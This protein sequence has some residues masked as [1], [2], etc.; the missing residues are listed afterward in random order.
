MQKQTK[1]KTNKTRRAWLLP[2]SASGCP[3]QAWG[4]AR[5]P[6]KGALLAARVERRVG[7]CE[8]VTGPCSRTGARAR[9]GA[10]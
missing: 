3:R 9:P 8:V 7:E 10:H 1:N 4:A 6:D 2:F 5:E